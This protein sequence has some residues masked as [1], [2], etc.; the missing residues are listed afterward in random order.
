YVQ[1]R[2]TRRPC[3][4]SNVVGVT[5][6]D[7]Q[8]ERGNNRLAAVRKTRSVV[9]SCGRCACRRSTAS[10]CRSTTIS[11]SLKSCERG[12]SKTSWSTPRTTRQQ[13]DQNKNQLIGFRGTDARLYD[14]RTPRRT[15]T[16][17]THPTRSASS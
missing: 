7:C 3:Q 4:R 8:R 11:S 9:V 5:R 12:R 15:G 1:R 6:N 14:R 13:S 17:L 16:E 10:S 2:A